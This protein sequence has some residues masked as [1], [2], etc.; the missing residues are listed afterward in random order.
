MLN[1]IFFLIFVTYF[2]FVFLILYH[3]IRFGIGKEPK[4]IAVFFF[5][6]SIFVFII[7]AFSFYS[8]NWSEIFQMI[9]I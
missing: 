3:L 9:K 4:R 6:G 8:I 5:F 1:L 7:F 2:W